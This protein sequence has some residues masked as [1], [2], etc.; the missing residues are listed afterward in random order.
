MHER[1]PKHIPFTIVS[2]DK[3]FI[4]VER[5]MRDSHRKAVVIDPHSAQQF[6]NDMI[7]TMV[8]SVADT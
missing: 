1:L 5:Q 3:G 2:G 8:T 7:Y 4:E 6:S